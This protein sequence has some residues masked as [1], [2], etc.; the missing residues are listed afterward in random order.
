MAAEIFRLLGKIGVDGVDDANKAIDGVNNKAGTLG[1][2][3]SS[4]G[5]VVA[6]IGKVVA[7][8]IGAASVA[9]GGLIKASVQGYAE[10]EQLVGGVDTLFKNSSEQVQRYAARAYRTAGMTANEYMSTVTSFSASLLQGLEGDTAK[11]AEVADM[12]IQDMSDN[13]NKMGT[14]MESIQAAYQG[15]AKGQYQLLDNLKLGYGGTKTEMERLLKD[16]TAITG[17]KYD[18]NNLADVYEAIHVIQTELNITGTTAREA[19]STISGSLS[20]MKSAWQN[21]VVGIADD[22][23]NMEALVKGFVD[24]TVAVANNLMPRIEQA[25]IGVGKLIEGLAPI[26]AEKLPGL[27]ESILPILL[28]AAVGL[29]ST[30]FDSLPELLDSMLP[31]IISAAF[32]VIMAFCDTVAENIGLFLQIG[33]DALLQIVSGITASLPSIIESA[34][35]IITELVNTLTKQETLKMLLDAALT[36]IESIVTGLISNLPRL[37]E[38][39]IQLVQNLVDFITEPGNLETILEMCVTMIITIMNGLIDAIPQL[40]EA[41]IQIV[42]QLV[43]FLL[44]PENIMMLVSAA[45]EIVLAIVGGLITAAVELVKGAD[46]LIRQLIDKFKE[47]D[48]A[49]TGRAIIDG[50]LEGL[51]AAWETVSAWFS[52]VW[53]SL[54]NKEVNVESTGGGGRINVRGSVA[55]DGGVLE[56]GQVAFLEG[57]G[58]EAIVPL[59][60]NRGWIK[61]VA[62]DM[63]TAFGG[64]ES[65]DLLRKIL[66][67]ITTMDDSM[68]EK[69]TTAVAEIRFDINNREFARMVKAVN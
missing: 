26:I 14:S 65:A 34:I 37:V 68:A 24:S 50:L 45:L 47:T 39:A 23:A 31:V 43:E 28:E 38:A 59:E 27:V 49:E 48:W 42:M 69:L 18:I 56:R 11:A 25:L 60:N 55:A 15:F 7:V 62:E 6:G 52:G 17:V 12:A 9:V 4:V 54:F 58:A 66:D 51:K 20:M 19:A 29:V 63:D 16:A 67:A 3:F 10:Y 1:K 44:D 8:G 57:A 64:S 40:V 5:K 13:A 30:V 22:D 33:M 21:L 53:N 36:L 32:S 41:A 61:R 46:E 2:T 35:T